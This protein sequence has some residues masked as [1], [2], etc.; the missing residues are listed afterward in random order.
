MP[1][2]A[3]LV[4]LGVLVASPV[5]RVVVR[6]LPTLSSDAVSG[7]AGAND[8]GSSDAGSNDAGSNDPVT[9][10][11]A[12]FEEDEASDDEAL[13]YA[14][15]PIGVPSPA[16]RASRQGRRVLGPSHVFESSP[17]RPPRA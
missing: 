5:E 13:V 14:L 17:E 9:P 7:D 16:G 11:S 4:C 3:L 12:P 8:A 1:S 2:P 10:D 6:A 15:S